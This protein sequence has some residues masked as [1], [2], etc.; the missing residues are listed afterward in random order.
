MILSTLLGHVIPE[1]APY[2]I[3]GQSF[4]HGVLT[5]IMAA[6]GDPTIP[7]QVMEIMPKAPQSVYDAA[8]DMIQT[9]INM[10][11]DPIAIEAATHAMSLSAGSEEDEYEG[12]FGAIG[13][14]DKTN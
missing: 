6:Y 4:H 9:A 13:L 10:T 14:G 1:S 2:P 5:G 11:K 12:L 3:D 7:E 8:R